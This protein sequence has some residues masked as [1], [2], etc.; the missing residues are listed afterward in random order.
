MAM[1]LKVFTNHSSLL[2]IGSPRSEASRSKLVITEGMIR[3]KLVMAVS[4]DNHLTSLASFNLIFGSSKI[5][6]IACSPASRTGLF[7]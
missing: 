1:K 6:S 5:A 2:A 7:F 3:S 4:C